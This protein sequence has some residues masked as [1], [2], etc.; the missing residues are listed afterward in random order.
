MAGHF[1]DHEDVNDLFSRTIRSHAGLAR[2]KRLAG[3]DQLD[4][5]P[6]VGLQRARGPAPGPV[7]RVVVRRG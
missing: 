2:L 6:E 1:S 4:E 5:G 7:P 3:D